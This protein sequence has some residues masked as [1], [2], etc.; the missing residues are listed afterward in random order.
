MMTSYFLE[1]SIFYEC[2]ELDWTISKFAAILQI[3]MC[4]N[5][6]CMRAPICKAKLIRQTEQQQIETRTIIILT[7]MDKYC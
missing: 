2:I 5:V 6:V 4:H 7:K 1:Q 3:L